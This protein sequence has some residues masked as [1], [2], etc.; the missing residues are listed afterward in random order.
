[1]TRTTHDAREELNAIATELANLREAQQLSQ[2]RLSPLYSAYIL[3]T[4]ESASCE[5]HG[6]Y[7]QQRISLEYAGRVSEKHSDCPQ[8]LQDA[9]DNAE[10]RKQQIQVD[11][12]TA[13]ASIS[14][15]FVGCEFSNYDELNADARHNVAVLKDYAAAW[16]T[17]QAAGT[18]LILCGA[19]GTGK[20]HLATALAKDIIRHHSSTVLMTSVMRIIRAVRRSWGK[21]AEASEEDVLWYYTSRDLLIIDEVGVQYGSDSEKIILFDILNTRYENMLPTVL[22]SNLAP[23]EIADVIGERLMD[24][25]AEGD[26]AT[27][28]FDW[29]SYRS[30][31]GAFPA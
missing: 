20:N 4:P 25:M 9:I 28:I 24:R 17:M 3:Q 12:L 8:C 21:E 29:P 30:R 23:A 14:P 11:E 27:L 1:M 16:P 31:K 19:P 7:L 26:G 15:R 22:I 6:E 18:S 5:Q 10:A 13:D 2:G